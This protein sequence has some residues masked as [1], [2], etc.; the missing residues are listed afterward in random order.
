MS[1]ILKGK[2]SDLSEEE[3]MKAFE[4]W[5]IEHPGRDE[6]KESEFI[7]TASVLEI[8]EYLVTSTLKEYFNKEFIE[9]RIEGEDFEEVVQGILNKA[10][11]QWYIEHKEVK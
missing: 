2:Y 11:D 4:E 9:D 6:G 10:V 8:A 1:G 5:A 7:E 3:K